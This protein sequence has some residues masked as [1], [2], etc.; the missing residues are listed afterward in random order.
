MPL[1]LV[2][3]LVLVLD[4]SRIDLFI[5]LFILLSTAQLFLPI[6]WKSCTLWH[7]TSYEQNKKSFCTISYLLHITPVHAS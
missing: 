5:Y 2:L 7:E 4:C 6:G 3:V 1:V